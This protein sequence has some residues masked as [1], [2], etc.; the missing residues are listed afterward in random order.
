VRYGLTRK[1]RCSP[2][3]KWARGSLRHKKGFD[4]QR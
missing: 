2:R 3:P 1:G 4:E